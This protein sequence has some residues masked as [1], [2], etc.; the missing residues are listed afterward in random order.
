MNRVRAC[1]LLLLLLVPSAGAAGHA[2]LPGGEPGLQSAL[3]RL[4]AAA[5]PAAS[6]W[7]IQTAERDAPR[8]PHAVVRTGPLAGANVPARSSTPGPHAAAAS[9][10]Q[11]Q[12]TPDLQPNPPP[13]DS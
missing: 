5:A 4:E 3:E 1:L 13:A 8:T 9:P 2:A 7:D 11:R 6:A 12:W 10:Q